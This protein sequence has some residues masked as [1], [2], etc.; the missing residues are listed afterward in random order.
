ML[1]EIAQETDGMFAFIPDASLVGFRVHIDAR[2]SVPR[3]S[4][5]PRR[6]AWS[7]MGPRGPSAR[8]RRS[9]ARASSKSGSARCTRSRR[10]R[11]C[12]R[13]HRRAALDAGPG[14]LADITGQVAEAV[15]SKA[16]FERWGT[17]LPALSVRR[18]RAP[19]VE[20]LQGP[21]SPSVRR[22]GLP[23]D[24]RFDRG[25][26]SLHSGAGAVVSHEPGGPRQHGCVHGQQ[27]AVLRGRRARRDA[28]RVAEK[29][30]TACVRA[31]S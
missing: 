4:R 27:R 14:L 12:F 3:R 2:E 18:P 30:L 21:R 8:E 13:A 24:P 22:A 1:D 15:S 25:R 16:H 11:S 23:R 26:V 6:S 31:T 20:Q 17:A 29:V 5:R 28:R 9:S 19:G 10:A 7:S